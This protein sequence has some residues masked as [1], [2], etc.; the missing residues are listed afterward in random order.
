MKKLS[1][2]FSLVFI[3]GI[4][5]YAT[6]HKGCDKKEKCSKEQKKCCKKKAKCDKSTAE[7]KACEPGCEKACCAKTDKKENN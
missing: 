2:L 3:L 5:S 7:K 6:T 4:A 1:L